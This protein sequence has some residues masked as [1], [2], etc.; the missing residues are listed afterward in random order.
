MAGNYDVNGVWKVADVA[1]KCTAQAPNQRPTMTDV[2]VQLQECV[3]L[4]DQH[5]V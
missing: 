1:L 3:E 4:E 2:V 5:F